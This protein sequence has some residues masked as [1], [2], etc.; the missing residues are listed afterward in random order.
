MTNNNEFPGHPLFDTAARMESPDLSEHPTLQAF[1]SG[2]PAGAYQDWE[3]SRRFLINYAASA[4]TY[5]RFRGELQRFLLFLWLISGRTLA[6]VDADDINRYMRFLKKPPKA[7]IAPD[8]PHAFQDQQG[9]RHCVKR[10]RPFSGDGQVRQATLDA[11]HRVLT[12][13]FRELVEQD[14]IQRSPMH[15][16]RR[17]ERKANRAGRPERETAPRFTDW[18]WTFIKE[19]LEGEADADPFWE[20]HLFTVMTMKALYLRVFELAP[21][22]NEF[23]NENFTPTMGDFQR[24]TIHGKKFWTLYVYGKG[25]KERW[26]TLPEA[27][28]P[29]LT[30]YREHRALPPYPSTGETSAMITHK[31][32]EKSLGK[33]RV[34]DLVREALERV[35][36]VMDAQGHKQEAAELQQNAGRTH[37]LRH[38]GASMDIEQ[39]RPIR[40]VSE[41]LGHA[42]VAITEQIYVNAD[43]AA[44]YDSGYSRA[45]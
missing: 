27:Y 18:Q 26:I 9:Q 28:L 41:E 17:R 24:K 19:T 11:A 10:W 31:H 6:E 45:I 25:E 20:R 5:S 21:R 1:L 12:I 34:E 38:T 32:S 33:A 43:A 7:W 22:H 4:A 30:R 37:L 44:K 39:G 2:M 14:Y 29:Y 15:Q 35:A 23:S 16:V 3:N 8:R 36:G 13:F 40:H 42:S